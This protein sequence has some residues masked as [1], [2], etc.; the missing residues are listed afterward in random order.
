MTQLHADLRELRG[1]TRTRFTRN[2]NNLVVT[3]RLSD[4]VAASA[5]RQ[6]RERH[7]GDCGCA[8]GQLFGSER[9]KRV[10]VFALRTA[11]TTRL[12]VWLGGRVPVVL[13]R[14]YGSTRLLPD[15]TFT[16]LPL[17]RSALFGCARILRARSTATVAALRRPR[18]IGRHWFFWHSPSLTRHVH[19]C[20]AR[21]V[22][23]WISA[24]TN[25]YLWISSLVFT[26]YA[27]DCHAV[28]IHS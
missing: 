1:F 11:P 6:V 26:P 22:R 24:T 10:R 28:R 12:V 27:T 2:D 17:A 15:A 16:L 7:D 21:T 19:T 23:V 14:I 20:G 18:F 3:Y 25:S 9:L 13:A 4:F 8:R 5:D